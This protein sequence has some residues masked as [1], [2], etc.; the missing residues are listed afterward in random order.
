[1]T[2]KAQD[3]QVNAI[4]I[5]NLAYNECAKNKGLNFYV[6]PVVVSKDYLGMRKCQYCEMG[7]WGGNEPA[8]LS[9]S[10]SFA[11]FKNPL[12]TYDIAKEAWKDETG[13]GP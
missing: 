4:C 8:K 3:A 9:K 1:M 5:Q 12:Y 7:E 2:A 11:L 13:G 6:C 10:C